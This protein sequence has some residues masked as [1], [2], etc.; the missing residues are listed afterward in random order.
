MSRLTAREEAEAIEQFGDDLAALSIAFDKRCS[1]M[2]SAATGR[3]NAIAHQDQLETIAEAF[4]KLGDLMSHEVDQHE[5]A[6]DRRRD[7]LLEPDHRRLG[8]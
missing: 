3:I 8:Q 6:E 4:R 7:N 2:S 1:R 5:E